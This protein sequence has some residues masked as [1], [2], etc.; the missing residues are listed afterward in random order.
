[1]Q[2][3]S[4]SASRKS[5]TP[6]HAAASCLRTVTDV[7]TTSETH[8]VDSGNGR[9]LIM[10]SRLLHRAE[11]P[12][13]LLKIVRQEQHQG[14]AVLRFMT[15][16]RAVRALGAALRTQEQLTKVLTWRCRL[17]AAPCSDEN[18]DLSSIGVTN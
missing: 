7:E 4:R 6:Q 14:R 2:D 9:R 10:L 13:Q 5:S 11:L 17:G 1:M 3:E 15:G 16:G 8:E 18:A 12:T